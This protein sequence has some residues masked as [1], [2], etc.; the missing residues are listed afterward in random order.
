MIFNN[1]R[2]FLINQAQL[3]DFRSEGLGKGSTFS[4]DLPLFL[5]EP[6]SLQQNSVSG[7]TTIEED[8]SLSTTI[9]ALPA[10]REE[11]KALGEFDH[12]IDNAQIYRSCT[13]VLIV[14]D[15]NINR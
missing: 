10:M 4:V 9:H 1:Y 2:F 14:D 15:S 13:N 12:V 11:G 3:K 8:E 6:R 5:E 7:M